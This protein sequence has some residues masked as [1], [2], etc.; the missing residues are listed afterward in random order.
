MRKFNI[1]LNK[2]KYNLIIGQNSIKSLPNQINKICPKTRKVALIVDKN[3]PKKFSSILKRILKKYEIILIR[4][5]A[6]EKNKSLD[7]TNSIIKK[8]SESEFNRNDLVIGVGGGIVGD[9]SA[10]ASSIYKRGINFI[11][12]PTT[13]LAQVDSAIGGKTG[14]NTVYGKN[15]IGTFSQPKLVIVDTSFLESLNKRE[16]ICGYAEILKHSLIHDPIFFNWLEKNSIKIL[17]KQ[18]EALSYAIYKSCK[19]KMFF[20][21]K[22]FKEKNLRMKLNFGHTF[23]HAIEA[24]TNYSKKI[25]H[26]E[27][28]LI[29][30]FIAIKFSY[31]QKI[32]SENTLKRVIDIYHKNKIIYDIKKIF[33]GKNI[34]KILNYMKNDKKN[35]DN[36]IN[37]ILL[38]KIGST[39]E[40]GRHK[41][42]LIKTKKLLNKII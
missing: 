16:I 33:G 1:R 28:V 4:F 9:V 6:N 22:D 25:N 27:A 20:V 2:G 36:K 18:P 11:N 5:I 13:L 34:F 8:L 19:I 42:D 40:P 17:N 29:G 26:G 24:S 7:N 39:T 3:V 15:L 35:I 37:L 31:L 41:F 38:K 14:V 23:A 10:F 30:M 21:E 32:C 12:L